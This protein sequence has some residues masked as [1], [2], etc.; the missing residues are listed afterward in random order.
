METEWHLSKPG[1]AKKVRSSCWRPGEEAQRA[2]QGSRL[3]IAFIHEQSKRFLGSSS[4]GGR[5]H[6]LSLLD[7]ETRRS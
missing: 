5:S 2:E 4:G 3:L 7:V 1:T 6:D